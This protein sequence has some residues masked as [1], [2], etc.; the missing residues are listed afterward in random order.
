M[1]YFCCGGVN[2]IHSCP[3]T[4]LRESYMALESIP[5]EPLCT[6][7]F[8][9]AIYRGNDEFMRELGLDRKSRE[10]MTALLASSDGG[11]LLEEL[12]E[13]PFRPKRRRFWVS[14]FSDGSFPVF[15]CSLEAETAEAEARH[16]FSKFAGRP[17]GE[18]RAWYQRFRCDFDGSVKDL[19][20][21]RAEWQQLTHDTDY[22]FCN[23][24]GAEAR[25]E[26]LDGLLAPSARRSEGTN[27]PV[28]KRSAISNPQIL[29]AVQ[30][31]CL[32]V[33]DG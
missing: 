17:Q 11:D 32:S 20:P 4:N 2:Q 15:Y 25:A 21:R 1:L 5:G 7:V 29:P 22:R 3:R 33:N 30:L 14:R 31:T 16:W 19:R 13:A 12:C 8:R 26:D 23:G 24:L 9:L 18:R 28:F 10:E 27:V 6:R